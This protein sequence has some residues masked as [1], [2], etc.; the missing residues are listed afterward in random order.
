MEDRTTDMFHKRMMHDTMMSTTELEDIEDILMAHR[1]RLSLASSPRQSSFRVVAVIFY[2]LY[3]SFDSTSTTRQH[4]VGSND[5]PCYIG[6]SIC[7]ERAAL[8]QLRFIPNLKQITKVIISTDAVHPIHPGMLCREFMSSHTAIDPQTLPIVMAGS[9]CNICGLDITLAKEQNLNLLEDNSCSDHSHRF[10]EWEI[11]KT[12]LCSIYPHPSLYTRLTASES[13]T[14]GKERGL[15]SNKEKSKDILTKLSTNHSEI[16]AKAIDIA[17]EGDDR[18]NL[19]P[20]QFGAAIKMSDGRIYATC[21][22]KA[23]EYGCSV[24]AVTQFGT[25]LS[26]NAK[27]DIHPVLLVQVDNFGMLHPPFATARAFLSEFG[28]GDCKVLT[29]EKSSD[30]EI[31]VVEISV[32]DLAPH[33]PN[34]GDLWKK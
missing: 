16:I 28:F 24:D 8:V 26:Q 34:M 17:C 31:E 7:A 22:R 23:L 30:D 9:I 14:L 25:I 20:V 4:V 10:H 32:K 13:V 6:G 27:K 29:M 1:Y 5:E 12:I 18:S 2:E 21:Q 15:L 11:T 3:D 33:S 19:H